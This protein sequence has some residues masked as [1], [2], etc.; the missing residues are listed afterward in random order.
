MSRTFWA[1]RELL[2]RGYR[3]FDIEPLNPLTELG[4]AIGQLGEWEGKISLLKQSMAGNASKADHGITFDQALPDLIFV[5][6]DIFT[7]VNLA[8]VML[9]N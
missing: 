9:S 6:S 2:K 4:E 3:G 7:A 1:G 8:N 5:Q